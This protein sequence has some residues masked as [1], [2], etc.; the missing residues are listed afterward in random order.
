MSIVKIDSEVVA[1]IKNALC[2]IQLNAEIVE[3]KY[4]ATLF[5]PQRNCRI[6]IKQIK[7]IDSLLP[8]VKFEGK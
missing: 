5:R 3:E 7:R 4:I 1:E 6:I 2:I 8:K